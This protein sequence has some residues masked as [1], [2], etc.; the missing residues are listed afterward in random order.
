M[1]GFWEHVAMPNLATFAF[2]FLPI[3]LT[4]RSRFR[5][6]AIGGGT[7]NLVTRAAYDRAGGHSALSDAV[8][9]DVGLARLIRR[10]GMRTEIVRADPDVHVRMYHG[11]SEIVSGFTKNSFVAFNRSYLVALFFFPF[12]L[13][14]HVLPYVFALL[15]NPFAIATVAVISLTRLILFTSLRYGVVNALF[16]HPL[17]IAVWCWIMLRSI[18]YTGIRREVQWRG[19]TYDSKKT[20]FGAD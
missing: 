1:H 6:L 3:W 18:W 13:A 9:D 2:S 14:L 8:I 20:K 15:G 7:G 10:N 16:G 12:A 4:N 17:M 19:R 11:L 5:L